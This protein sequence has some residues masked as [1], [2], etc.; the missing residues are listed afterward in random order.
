[1]EETMLTK[2][3]NNKKEKR[4]IR[5]RMAALPCNAWCTEYC[6]GINATYYSLRDDVFVYYN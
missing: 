4:E 6:G 2:L 3:T 1:M 5:E